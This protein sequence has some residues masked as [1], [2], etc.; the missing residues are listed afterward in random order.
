M[1]KMKIYNKNNI[2]AQFYLFTLLK[3]FF[4]YEILDR[5]ILYSKV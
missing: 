1:Q 2:K 3:L 4:K 5:V